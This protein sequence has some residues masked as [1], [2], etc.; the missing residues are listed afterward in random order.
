MLAVAGWAA[1]QVPPPFSGHYEGSTKIALL[2]ATAR[3]EIELKRSARY[4]LYTME[5][6]VTWAFL[7]RR[8]R[9][10]SVLRIDGD[11]MWPL[12]YLHV[13]ESSPK[14]DVHTRFD[15]L[16]NRATTRLGT[17]ADTSSADIAWPT[18]DPMSFQVALIA[19]APQR[20]SGVT[21]THHVIERGASKRH[22]V[23]FAGVTALPG[24]PPGV[25]AHEIVS[26]KDDKG[27]VALYLAPPPS[28]QPLRIDIDDITIRLAGSPAGGA[29]Q[30]LAEEPVPVCAS[31]GAQ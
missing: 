22:Q 24:A 26:R 27:R 30:A 1:A 15:W 28:W 17:A 3:A 19:L 23:S 20:Q 4:I 25:Q 21:E 10:C 6:T 13:D 31:G 12:E 18:W 14:F 11:R 16:Q 8:F 29:S 5:S 2:T 7:E 9:D